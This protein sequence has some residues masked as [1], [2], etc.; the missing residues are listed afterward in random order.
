L[1]DPRAESIA[2]VFQFMFLLLKRSLPISTRTL[3]H[4]VWATLL[5]VSTVHGQTTTETVAQPAAKVTARQAEW[6]QST[7]DQ[8]VKLA[9]RVGEEGAE[10]F[11]AGTAVAPGP[12]TAVG[13]VLGGATG[14]V[15]GYFGGEAAAE[16][17]ATWVVETIHDTGNTV[18]E[19]AT[20]AWQWSTTPVRGAWNRL[21]GE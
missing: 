7:I 2:V 16:K 21:F 17:A 1:S 20:Q 6:L 12:G 19:A 11:A 3:T 4:A 9:E 5:F 18:S 15:V 13:A 10:A 14:G 8:R